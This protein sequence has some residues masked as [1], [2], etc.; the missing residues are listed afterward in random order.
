MVDSTYYVKLQIYSLN[1]KTVFSKKL[2]HR[3]GKSAI[4]DAAVETDSAADDHFSQLYA[5]CKEPEENERKKQSVLFAINNRVT[6]V[7][8]IIFDS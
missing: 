1:L 4:Q 6:H 5:S 2:I 3:S 8:K 7:W